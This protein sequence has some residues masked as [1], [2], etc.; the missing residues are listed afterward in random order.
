M[1]KSI[2]FK[3]A[4]YMTCKSWKEACRNISKVGVSMSSL[5]HLVGSL[6]FECEWDIQFVKPNKWQGFPLVL[7]KN[8]KV[9]LHLFAKPTSTDFHLKCTFSSLKCTTS[10]QEWA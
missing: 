4:H 7:F 2:T 10:I 5:N 9:E 1:E 8:I 3:R 6:I